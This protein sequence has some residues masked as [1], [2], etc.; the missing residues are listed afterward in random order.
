MKKLCYAFFLG[1]SISA[2]G[3]TVI[4]ADLIPQYSVASSSDASQMMT[5]CRLT[6]TGLT[7]GYTY[8]YASAIS[9]NA[10]VPLGTMPSGGMFMINDQPGLASADI[11]GYTNKKSFSGSIIHPGAWN[12]AATGGYAEFT[13]T[14]P[15]YTGWFCAVN[16]GTAALGSQVYF[17][18]FI[19]DGLGGSSVSQHYRSAQTMIVRDYS[20]GANGGVAITST[21]IASNE[22]IVAL[23]DNISGTGSPLF[24]TWTENDGISQ[25]WTT[26]YNTYFATATMSSGKWGGWIP[27]NSGSGLMSVS[28]YDGSANVQFRMIDM[29]NDGQYNGNA[30]QTRNANSGTTPLQINGLTQVEKISIVRSME[31]QRDMAL[32]MFSPDGQ[33]ELYANLSVKN[34]SLSLNS[35]PILDPS[36]GGYKIICDNS[37]TLTCA[38]TNAYTLPAYFTVVKNL[39][40]S[41]PSGVK[42]G[43]NL[44]VENQLDLSGNFGP[45]RLDLNNFKLTLNGPPITPA[46]S[47]GLFVST[48]SSTQSTLEFTGNYPGVYIPSG[49]SDVKNLIVSNPNGVALKAALD[50]RGDLTFSNNALINN[51]TFSLNIAGNIYGQGGQDLSSTGQVLI[52]NPTNSTRNIQGTWSVLTC[53]TPVVLNGDLTCVNTLSINEPFNISDY[54]L[55][56]KGDWIGD[57]SF[58][59]GG[60]TSSIEFAR[61]TP[62]TIPTTANIYNIGSLIINNNTTVSLN[63]NAS[64]ARS[65]ELLKGTLLDGGNIITLAGDIKGSATIDGAG[66]IIMTGGASTQYISDANINNLELNNNVGFELNGANTGNTNITKQ[67]NLVNGVLNVKEKGLFFTGSNASPIIRTNGKIQLTK[68]S[69]FGLGSKLVKHTGAAYS[70]PSGLFVLNSTSPT[71]SAGAVELGTL[72]INRTNSITLNTQPLDIHKLLSVVEG[73]VILPDNYQIDLKSNSITETAIVD[74]FTDVT[75]A[76]ITYGTNSYFCVER[77]IPREVDGGKGRRAFR[78]LAPMVVNT[79]GTIW[80]NWQEGAP[81]TPIAGFGTHITGK[82][83]PF[84]VNDAATGF[85]MTTSGEAGGRIYW[86]NP[87]TGLP[88]WTNITNTKTMEFNGLLPYRIMIRGDRTYNDWANMQIT[89]SEVR[90]RSKGRLIIGDVNITAAGASAV[91]MGFSTSATRMN[92]GSPTGFTMIAN[93]YVAPISWSSLV[94]NNSTVL[95]YYTAVEANINTIGG[96]VNYDLLLGANVNSSSITNEIQPGQAFFVRNN[97]TMPSTFSIRESDK[98][99]DH[100]KLTTIYKSAHKQSNNISKIR[101]QL[102]KDIDAKPKILDGALIGYSTDFSDSVDVNDVGKWQN[103]ANNISILRNGKEIAI[104]KRKLINTNDT[105]PLRLGLLT[106]GDSSYKIQIKL[107]EFSSSEATEILFYDALT[108]K[109]EYLNKGADYLFPFIPGTAEETFKNRFSVILRTAVVL[110]VNFVNFTGYIKDQSVQLDWHVSEKDIDHYVIMRSTDGKNF[111]ALSKMKSAGDGDRYYTFLDHRPNAKNFYRIDAIEKTGKITSTNVMKI[112]FAKQAPL[113]STYPNPAAEFINVAMSDLKPGNKIN[114]RLMNVTGLVILED[115]FV[116][117]SPSE[118]R[119]LKLNVVKSGKYFIQVYDGLNTNTQTIEIIK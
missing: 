61:T 62:Q 83:G 60:V 24:I 80:D 12:I 73:N 115:G 55:T 82:K 75:K 38:G 89:N 47:P 116:C 104:E 67:L 35:N 20:S 48:G 1:I 41:N 110:P 74:K 39:N 107:T 81:A 4:N 34:N 70:I 6:L 113:I 105:I 99:I 100:G 77:I 29:N 54:K 111:Q 13:A 72:I 109:S 108:K 37:S 69:S 27:N 94:A 15:T 63:K 42:L 43:G 2:N 91:N 7:P 84:G 112:E 49:L 5:V 76:K 17:Y 11:V 119:Q 31:L 114:V 52:D 28:Y 79:V 118:V 45:G 33:L 56:I 23:Y 44:V 10:A 101:L 22:Q 26:W 36:A 88:A 103:L 9:G 59:S 25:Q 58:V 95:S 64:L 66:K 98:V 87:V 102:I 117:T 96:Y 68:M 71:R 21:S 16:D 53:N 78:D 90:L 30:V 86:T 106:P 93:P 50:I 19:N 65:L 92:S 18:V 51:A 8:R 3:Q 40:V 85:D 57:P 14:G 46:N 97:G 32:N